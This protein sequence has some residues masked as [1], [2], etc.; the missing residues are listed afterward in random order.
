MGRGRGNPALALVAGAL[1]V[2]AFAACGAEEHPNESRLPLPV[3]VT[4]S[5]SEEA[6][7]LSPGSIGFGK[8]DQQ[9]VAQ[10]EKIA[11]PEIDAD[12]PQT[13]NFTVSNTTDFDTAL[14]INGPQ[15]KRS[16][17]IVANGTGRYKTDLV[18]GEYTIGAADIPGATAAPFSIGPKR[19]SSSNDLLLP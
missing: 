10:N 1:T 6:I 9:Q 3:E 4:V 13:I 12:I 7:T 19:A 17:P 2:F 18:T 16:G 5:I 15:A 11:Q 14:E 8:P